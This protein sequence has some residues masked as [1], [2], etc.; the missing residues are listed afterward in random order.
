MG[1]LK[2]FRFD[3]DVSFRESP[4]SP[5]NEE[6]KRRFTGLNYFPENKELCM[7]LFLERHAQPQQVTLQTSTGDTREYTLVGEIAFEY[8]GVA[9]VLDVFEDDYGFF[10]P[11]SDESAPAETYG[12]GRYMEPP[13]IRSDILYVDFNLAYNP[14]CAY[15]EG[16]S[17]P[18]P[19]QRNRLAVRIDAG[20][21]NFSLE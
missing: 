2:Q 15:N 19:H 10:I 1:S 18:M 3:K 6:Q 11:F 17:C 4:Q 7:E 16:W 21:M 12:G 5:L 13:E 9:C 8:K 14:Y 20:E